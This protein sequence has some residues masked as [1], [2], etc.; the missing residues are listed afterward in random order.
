MVGN[1]KYALDSIA[2][3]AMISQ[4][5]KKNK[6]WQ[7]RRFKL[8]WRGPADLQAVY[9]ENNGFSGGVWSM[10]EA[11]R[12][13]KKEWCRRLTKR[14]AIKWSRSP[15]IR[16]C[17]LRPAVGPLPLLAFTESRSLYTQPP[18]SPNLVPQVTREN[19]SLCLRQLLGI[20]AGSGPLFSMD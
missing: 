6:K 11:D 2:G 14:G 18:A 7:N 13:E 8:S 1:P 3:R 19:D 4:N 9:S 15:P 5:K 20:A 12:Y 17:A 16:T 10:G